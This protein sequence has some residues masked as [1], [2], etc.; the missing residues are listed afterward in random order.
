MTHQHIEPISSLQTSCSK[1]HFRTFT[2]STSSSEYTTWQFHF[3]QL[4]F[5]TGV[6]PT[7]RFA[8]ITR[9]SLRTPRISDYKPL[10]LHQIYSKIYT[11][12]PHQL[13]RQTKTELQN[14]HISPSKI[15]I[16]IKSQINKTRHPSNYQKDKKEYTPQILE[17]TA[18]KPRNTKTFHLM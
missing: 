6:P 16:T 11:I 18:A 13:S 9:S 14:T 7:P 17:I 8:R 5:L 12:N 15:L 3:I 1:H 10:N 4:I 2:T